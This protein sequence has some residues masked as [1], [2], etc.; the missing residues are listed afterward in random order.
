MSL[1]FM[2]FCAFSVNSPKVSEGSF[3]NESDN[4]SSIYQSYHN[5][6]KNQFVFWIFYVQLF[7]LKCA[8]ESRRLSSFFWRVEMRWIAGFFYRL[9][10][11]KWL[12]KAQ[13]SSLK[14]EI[15]SGQSLLNHPLVD[16]AKMVGKALHLMASFISNRS[17]CDQYPFKWSSG[18]PAL[19]YTCQW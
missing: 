1:A 3:P 14:L 13:L 4:F 2:Y 7:W 18:S 11:M 5:G 8:T 17:I 12:I 9:L 19:V 16:P 15:K 6:C 10:T